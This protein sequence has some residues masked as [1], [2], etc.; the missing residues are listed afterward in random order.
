M[1]RRK[2]L[3]E[4][5]RWKEKKDR[6]P[7]VIR[8]AR[9]VGKTTVV[10][11]FSK[12]FDQYIYLN[13]EISEDREIFENNQSYEQ[14]LDGIYFIKKKKKNSKKKTLIFIDEIQNSPEAV[15]QL[16]YFYENSKELFVIAAGSLL[17]T[18][19][20][21]NIN[22]PVGRV[23][24]M[25][26]RPLSFEEF[27]LAIGEKESVT[28]LNKIPLPDYA[29]KKLLNLFHKFVL[30][31]GMPEVVKKFKETRDLLSIDSIFESLII[32]Y[33]ED[34][35]KYYSTNKNISIMR[36]V[37]QNSFFEAGN[38][39][40]FQGFGNS[41]YK[42]REINESL[43]LLENAFLLQLIY[44]TTNNIPPI[45][46]NRK[47]APRLQLLDTGLLNHFLNMKDDIFQSD[48]IN[49]I[50]KG[51]IAEHIVGQE[52]LT[53]SYSYLHKLCFWVREKKQSNAEVDFIIQHKNRLIPLEVKSGKTG[54]LRSLHQFI[55]K[56]PHN[57]AIRLYAGQIDIYD[58]KT[59][60]KKKYKILN[61]PYYLTSK[62]DKYIDLYGE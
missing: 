50:Y 4:L 28:I 19:I 37:V 58:D 40:K 48:D 1:F 39:I 15:K 47:K 34:V 54:R 38:R 8:G 11:M 41:N 21:K 31:G 36:F 62:I 14:L 20:K 16:R 30:V 55:D 61:L 32:S 18:L 7:L 51:K 12:E 9:Q 35:E 60:N 3:D 22:F 59:I 5:N 2:I 43:Q 6:K 49:N 53:K 42:S 17:E 57:L 13:L 33:L 44:P 26:L 56:A 52:L 24:F 10:N 25:V 29:H 45:I 27:L 46:L 23:E